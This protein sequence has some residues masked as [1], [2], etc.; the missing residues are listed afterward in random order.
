MVYNLKYFFSY[1]ADRDTRVVNGASDYW[2]AEIYQLDFAGTAQEIEAAASPVLFNYKN[3]SDNKFESLRGSECTLNLIATDNFQLEDLYTENEI[4]FLVKIYRNYTLVWQGFIIPDNCQESF[5]FP[6]YVVSVNCVDGLG[7]LKNYSFAQDDGKLW[8]GRFSFLDII[9]KCLSKLFIPDIELYTCVNIYEISMLQGDFYD[10]LN[11]TFVNAERYF[12]DDGF[13]PMDCES[14][15]KSILQEWTSCIIQSEGNWYIFR[16]N[17]AALSGN[18]VFRKY[19]GGEMSYDSATVTKDINVRLGGESEGIVFA[20]LF[21]INTDQTKLID[22][23][24]K[25]ASIS[26]KYGLAQ[27]LIG[28]PNLRWTPGP[29]GEELLQWLKSDPLLDISSDPLG[30]TRIE[31]LNLTAPYAYIYNEAPVSANEGDILVVTINYYNWYADGPRAI[32]IL[33]DGVETYYADTFG[34]WQTIAFYLVAQFT[35]PFF[36]GSFVRQLDPLPISGDLTLQL[37]QATDEFVTPGGSPISITYR[38]ADLTPVVDEED[39]IGEIHTAVQ[40]NKYTFIPDT[41]N[42]FNGD[43][44]SE[45]FVGVMYLDDADTL[46]SLWVRR[47]LSESVLCQPFADSK[48]FLRI[49]VEEMVR[50]Y[51]N[52]FIKY[53]GSIF[54]YFNPLSRF[55]INLLDGVFMP[56]SLTYDTQANICKAVLARV[57][58]DEVEMDYTLAGDY[59]ETTKVTIR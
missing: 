25:N 21:H 4:D 1:Y 38:R 36:E 32:L 2:E 12:K 10:P 52:P 42:V 41:L 3:I 15:L 56:L 26:Y 59:G 27:T 34:Q 35:T 9:Y 5:I 40:T 7:L 24:Y 14:V 11:L 45:Q 23:P 55:T 6:P 53:E 20:P 43:G 50:M 49:A 51:A 16:N 30:G 57:S 29:F 19:L 46:T 44:N 54:G 18:L 48:P 22:R 31:Q 8:I 39:P 58:N 33:T 13:T 47:G 17:E 37:F 28:N